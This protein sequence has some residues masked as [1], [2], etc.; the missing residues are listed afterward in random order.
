MNGRLRD[1][2]RVLDRSMMRYLSV[3]PIVE[4][5]DERGR[6]DEC[7]DDVT[8]LIRSLAEILRIVPDLNTI[9]KAEL[10]TFSKQ[11]DD[12]LSRFRNEGFLKGLKSRPTP[13][14]YRREF[15]ARGSGNL[16]NPLTCHHGADQRATKADNY[17]R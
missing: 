4:E 13:S 2:K 8:E 9:R 10:E 15:R 6:Y 17:D 14:R 3:V 16:E 5:I 12:R 7:E 11:A 1:T